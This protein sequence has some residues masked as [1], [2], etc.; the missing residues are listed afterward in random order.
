MH[1]RMRH[2]QADAALPAWRID[3]SPNSSAR[4]EM[5][6][7]H[8]TP[9]VGVYAAVRPA[10]L[11][12]RRGEAGDGAGE[13]FG[14]IAAQRLI[15]AAVNVAAVSKNAGS[16]L[17]PSFRSRPHRTSSTMRSPSKLTVCAKSWHAWLME[18]SS[19]GSSRAVVN[20]SRTVIVWITAV[21]HGGL[22]RLAVPVDSDLRSCR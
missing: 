16:E 7:R 5:S 14:T 21:G 4:R 2:S 22:P 20:H 10:L 13:L 15:A 1:G 8:M 18:V 17:T 9:G 6:C 12:D 19:H 3:T 11:D